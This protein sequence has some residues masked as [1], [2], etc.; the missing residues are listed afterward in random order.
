MSKKKYLHFLQLWNVAKKILFTRK[1]F[2]YNRIFP[3]QFKYFDEIKRWPVPETLTTWL[4]QN[5]NQHYRI[6]ELDG[7][8]QLGAHYAWRRQ[9]L[10][11]A[12]ECQSFTLAPSTWLPHNGT[13]NLIG[14]RQLLITPAEYRQCH[15]YHASAGSNNTRKYFR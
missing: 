4:P 10:L 1:M 14:S 8:P 15:C 5:L 7:G 11:A 6:E 9:I 3:N 13:R 12:F 2:E